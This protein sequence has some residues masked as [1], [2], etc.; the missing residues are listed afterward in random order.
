MDQ[1]KYQSMKETFERDARITR[2]PVT[3][4]ELEARE[5]QRDR[6]VFTSHLEPSYTCSQ[7]YIEPLHLQHLLC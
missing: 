3:K 6:P 7:E 5:K 1:T 2:T 4:K